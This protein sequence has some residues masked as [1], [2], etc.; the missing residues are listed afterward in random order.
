[1]LTSQGMPFDWARDQGTGRIG[2]QRP[3]SFDEPLSV[4]ELLKIGFRQICKHIGVDRVLSER[5]LIAC[6]TQV[7]QPVANFHAI[8]PAHSFVSLF[9][10]ECVSTPKHRRAI[11]HWDGKQE[12]AGYRSFLLFGAHSTRI[13]LGV[14]VVPPNR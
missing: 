2:L 1:S 4:A 6:E 3:N 12:D 5:R 9:C 8:I 11:F 14:E 10:F 13:D 7:A